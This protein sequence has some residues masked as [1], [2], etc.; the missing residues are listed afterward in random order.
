MA[1]Q[2]IGTVT[3]YFGKIH[4]AGIEITEGSLSVGDTIH[5]SGHTSDFTQIVDS[6]QIDNVSVDTAQVGDTI[7][8]KAVEHARVHDAVYKVVS[9]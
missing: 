9:E 5:V 2:R 3:H 1:E 8:L 7:G 6:M 4:V